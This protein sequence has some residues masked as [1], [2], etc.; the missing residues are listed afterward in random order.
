MWYNDRMSKKEVIF[1]VSL[2]LAWG[3][4]CALGGYNRGKVG[5]EFDRAEVRHHTA[6]G[7]IVTVV[8]RDGTTVWVDANEPRNLSIPLMRRSD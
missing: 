1:V 8:M 7:R 3:V 2:F 4:V 6:E 5:A